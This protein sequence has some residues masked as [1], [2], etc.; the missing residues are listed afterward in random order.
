MRSVLQ[1]PSCQASRLGLL[2][3]Q[4]RMTWSATLHRLATSPGSLTSYTDWGMLSAVCALTSP[5]A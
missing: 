1:R 5:A 2:T 4:N 3:M